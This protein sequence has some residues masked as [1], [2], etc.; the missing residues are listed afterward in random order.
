MFPAIEST[1]TVYTVS[2]AVLSSKYHTQCVC[3]LYIQYRALKFNV[4]LVKC[5]KYILIPGK[6]PFVF[7]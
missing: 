6:Y 4:F 5:C 3:V 2:V 1:Y 7:L